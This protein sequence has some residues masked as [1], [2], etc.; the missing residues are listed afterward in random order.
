MR[1]VKP[2]AIGILVTTL[3]VVCLL[4]LP[5]W[6]CPVELT[7]ASVEAVEILGDEDLPMRLV[8]LE[9]RNRQFAE[10]EFAPDIPCETKVAGRWSGS[11]ECWGLPR[12]ARYTPRSGSASR[13]QCALL[14]PADA[15]ACRLRLK[16][17]Y[18]GRVP[19]PLGIGDPWARLQAPSVVSLRVQ[20][21]MAR[22]LPGV[23]NRL[24][25]TAF[26]RPPKGTPE[27]WR[28][29]IVTVTLPREAMKGNA[30]SGPAP[31]Q[32]VPS[33]EPAVSPAAK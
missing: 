13:A 29:A 24:W 17:R 21:V 19:L 10:I 6:R 2:M 1:A 9:V 8:N 11:S 33:R 3:A 22:I 32:T 15:Q 16:Y 12:I 26:T 25:P 27:P 14:V 30:T 5:R 20:Q 18:G 28:E 7:V 4:L 31:D 23:Y